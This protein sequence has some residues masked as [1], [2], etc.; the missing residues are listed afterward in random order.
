MEAATAYLPSTERVKRT[1]SQIQ[2]EHCLTR[3]A[4]RTAEIS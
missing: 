2:K 3:I 1:L 4:I